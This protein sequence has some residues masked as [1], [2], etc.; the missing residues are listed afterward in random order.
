VNDTGSVLSASD[1]MDTIVGT[2]LLG[3]VLTSLALIIAGLTW[4]WL[5]TGHSALEE[6]L[7][8]HDVVELLGADLRALAQ[9][10]VRPRLLISLGVVALLL[11]PYLRVLA[12]ML[13]FALVEHNWK[14]T[15]FTA[16][17]LIVL[18]YS[19]VLR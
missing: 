18:T 19:L 17:V 14:Y 6:T 4:H 2:L 3:G 5:T 8:G 12:S 9:G 13:Y 11:T 15:A 1:R 7:A 10:A 16:F